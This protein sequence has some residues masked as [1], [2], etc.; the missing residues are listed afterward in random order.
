M[1]LA[2]PV[3]VFQPQTAQPVPVATIFT[4]GTVDTCVRVSS[5]P[6]PPPNNAK[7]VMPPAPIA[8]TA[9]P[10]A[11]LLVTV[12]FICTTLAVLQLVLVE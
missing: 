5:I 3:T 1:R 8:L 10:L 4:Q 6:I 11:A 7:P 2:N 12:R 9:L